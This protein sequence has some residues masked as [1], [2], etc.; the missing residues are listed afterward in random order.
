MK[1]ESLTAIMPTWGTRYQQGWP[2]TTSDGRIHYIIGD[3]EVGL[4]QDNLVKMAIAEMSTTYKLDKPSQYTS[5]EVLIIGKLMAFQNLN[6]IN[7][8][9]CHD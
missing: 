9:T 7:D 2:A 1:K 4:Q 6:G 8:R 5:F 3:K